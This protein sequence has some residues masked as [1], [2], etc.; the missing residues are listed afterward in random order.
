MLCH[1]AVPGP[2]NGYPPR[3]SP[4]AVAS[5]AVRRVLRGMLLRACYE[6]CSTEQGYGATECAW[7]YGAS[8]GPWTGE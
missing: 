5:T 2:A 4:H 3:L 6:V 7:V 1:Y 8:S